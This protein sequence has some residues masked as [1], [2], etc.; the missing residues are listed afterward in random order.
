MQRP[1]M[2]GNPP[3]FPQQQQ[4]TPKGSS[5]GIP[6]WLVITIIGVIVVAI[7]GGAFALLHNSLGTGGSPSTES[8]STSFTPVAS[9]LQNPSR[10]ATL[11][12]SG[13]VS[14]SMVVNQFMACGPLAYQG[15]QAYSGNA[16]GTIGGTNYNFL[17]VALN[18]NGPGTYTFPKVAAT[19][20]IPGNASKTWAIDPTASS[21]I[22]INSDGKSGTL[23]LHLFNPA[24][25]T[26]KVSVTGNWS[27]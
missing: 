11:T 14:G 21:T 16:T 2:P 13:D 12:F 6:R 23:N 19:L 9:C 10:S 27:S 22:T 3:Q 8:G 5:G 15:K 26:S 7:G 17:F 18:Y 20:A 4:A 1:G 25:I 24:N